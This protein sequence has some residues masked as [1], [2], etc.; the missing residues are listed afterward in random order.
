[1]SILIRNMEMPKSCA[2][3][4]IACR[5]YLDFGVDGLLS[6]I[7]RTESRRP[8]CLLGPVQSHGQWKPRNDL[9][10]CCYQCSECGFIRDA[11][12]LDVNNFCPN[13][14]ADMK[15]EN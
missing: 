10:D 13:C 7:C 15:G 1:M 8:D 3:C 14:G 9:G 2:S 4:N 11:Y 12:I 5:F 6:K